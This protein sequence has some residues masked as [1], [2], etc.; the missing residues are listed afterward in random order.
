MIKCICFDF[1]NTL[2]TYSPPREMAYIDVC[3][4]HGIEINPKNL[5]RS[6]AQVDF[7]WR[8][9]NRKYKT[10]KMRKIRQFLFFLGYIKKAVKGA[11]YNINNLIAYEIL[12]TMMKMKWNF[13]VFDDVVPVLQD[14]KKR[15]YILGII[16]NVDQNF[17]TTYKSMS[18]IPYMDFYVT[19][20]EAGCDKPA[21][22]I[23]QLALD[24]SGVTGREMLYIGDQYDMD[25]VGAR[26]AGITPILIDRNNWFEDI[27]D[28]IRINSMY[29]IFKYL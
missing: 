15:N 25:V 4:K 18:F 8:E 21:R 7:E 10:G 6:L 19:S 24:K 11:G 27:T 28:C 3:K 14:L 29:D 17:E 5:N 16:S 9:F 23:F 12:S 2:T 22:Q 20:L 26:N 13:V 1:F